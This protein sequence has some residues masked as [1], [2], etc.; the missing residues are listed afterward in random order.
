LIALVKLY[1]KIMGK[2]LRYYLFFTVVI[3]SAE[4]KG[5]DTLKSEL[6]KVLEAYYSKNQFSGTVLVAKQGKILYENAYG[7]ADWKKGVANTVDTKFLIGSATKS[8]TA[9][10]VM[11]AREHGLLKLDEPLS[12]YIPELNKELGQ[13][14]L[15][16][17]MKNSSGLPVHLSRISDL[18]HRN[19]QSH[20]LISLYNSVP[21]S[22]EPGTRYE[23]SNLNYQLAALV[24]ERVTHTKYKQYLEKNIFEPVYMKSTGIERAHLKSKDKALGHDFVKGKFIRS[25]ENYMSF[26]KGGGDMYSNVKDIFKWDRALYSDLL[27]NEN[28]KQLMFDGTPEKFG[29]YGYGFKIK[30]YQRSATGNIS[31]KLVR[32]GGSMYGYIC[33]IHRYLDDGV[34]IVVLGNIRPYPTMEI[35]VAIEKVLRSKGY[36]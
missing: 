20:E 25:E 6:D 8:F 24:L 32:H 19:I 14:T 31:G 9:I 5:Q 17:L 23:Y 22:F 26:A 36:I 11:K 27:L 10:A 2:L 29:G 12:T 7:M 30:E 33:N 1:V 28:S 13:L 34:L 15:H 4:V 3:F 16:L 35:T 18:Q 21:L